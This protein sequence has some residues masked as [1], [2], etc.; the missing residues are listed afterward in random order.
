MANEILTKGLIAAMLSYLEKANNLFLSNQM[1]ITYTPEQKLQYLNDSFF[2]DTAKLLDYFKLILSK[3]RIIMREDISNLVDTLDKVVSY[4]SI[5][6]IVGL[7][8]FLIFIRPMFINRFN[9]DI[10]RIRGFFLVISH[11][12]ILQQK[13]LKEKF[14]ERIDQL[15][16]LK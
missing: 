2:S 8:L 14:L 15:R 3:S 13:Q 7:V 10:A 9:Q 1:T 12:T 11:Q 6:L 4:S 16:E 5:I